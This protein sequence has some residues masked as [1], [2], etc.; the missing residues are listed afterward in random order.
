MNG[1]RKLVSI[2]EVL[3]YQASLKAVFFTF[4]EMDIIILFML[5][6]GLGFWGL[7]LFFFSKS[8]NLFLFV[9]EVACYFFCL[10]VSC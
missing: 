10:G 1:V 6:M 5:A 3:P 7:V 2:M 9:G 4:Q 8:L